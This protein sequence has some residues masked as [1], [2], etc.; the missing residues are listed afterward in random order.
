MLKSTHTGGYSV[1]RQALAGA[2]QAAG[3]S[4]RAL[5]R[6]LRMPHTWV[7]KIESGERRVD[8]IECGWYLDAC[9]ADA[10]AVL[11]RVL[12]AGA[13]RQPSRVSKGGR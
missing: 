5:A 6:R 2:R 8:L 11:K 4:Q 9:G 12:Q 10:V 3:L 7:A 13:K 1:L